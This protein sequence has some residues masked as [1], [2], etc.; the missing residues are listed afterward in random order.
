VP[1]VG[2]H[3]IPVPKIG[4]SD[5]MNCFIKY[6]ESLDNSWIIMNWFPGWVGFGFFTFLTK[7][8]LG[9]VTY[10]PKVPKITKNN[11]FTQWP[12]HCWSRLFESCTAVYKGPKFFFTT[13]TSWV[14]KSPAEFYVDFKKINLPL[15]Q[16]APEKSYSRKKN[17]FT[18]HA[19]GPLCTDE[20]L[21]PGISFLGAFC[22]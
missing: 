3:S 14:L 8:P 6:N 12:L 10:L 1:A 22:H 18:T 17:F 11:F 4:S 19:G 5:F 21:Y 15:W 16:N 9:F 13:W 2:I 7:V 20:N